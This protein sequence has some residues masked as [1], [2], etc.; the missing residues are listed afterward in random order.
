ME[1]LSTEEL[2][3][4]TKENWQPWISEHQNHSQKDSIKVPLS[5]K[6]TITHKYYR[7]ASQRRQIKLND[8]LNISIFLQ[9]LVNRD[10][11][12]DQMMQA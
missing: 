4:L 9:T 12:K 6:K 7:I 8:S 2:T 10:K 1:F 11:F 3:K 5:K